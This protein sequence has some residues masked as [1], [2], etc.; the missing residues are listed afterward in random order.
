M[1]NIEEISE[2][3]SAYLDGE[4][5]GEETRRVEEMLADDPALSDE[6]ESLREVRQLLRSLPREQAPDGL[7]DAALAQA[8]RRRSGWRRRDA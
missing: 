3:L 5:S 6:L 1:S 4:L 7:I 8:Q 2:Q